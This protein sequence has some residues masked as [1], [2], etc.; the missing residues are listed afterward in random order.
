MYVLRDDQENI[1]VNTYSSIRKNH[2]RI[3]IQSHV[4]SGKTVVA[5]EITRRAV[6]KNN[7][8]LFLAPRRQL[9]YQTVETFLDFGIN[10]GMI[11]AGE[12]RSPSKLVQV[13][14]FDTITSRVGNGRMELPEASL[15]IVD[16]AHLCVSPARIA[17]LKNYNIVL[18]LTA[19]PALANGKGMGFFYEDIVESLTM[20]QMVDNGFLVPMRYFIGNAPDVSNV[21]LNADGD[22][23]EKELASVNDTPELIGDVFSN[24]K[25][26]AGDRCT[27]V[28]AVNRKHAVHLHNEWVSH[29]ITTEYIDGNTPPNERESIK[30]NVMSGITQVVINIGVMVAGVNWPRFDCVVIARQTRNISAW[31]QMI[32]RTSRLYP[33]KTE[34]L[35][36]YHG[37]NFEE[38]GRIDDPIEWSLD[39]ISTVKERKEKAQKAAKEPKEMEC[40][41]GAIFKARRICPACGNELLKK[42]EQIPFHS[43][44]LQEAIESK[45]EKYKPADKAQWYSEFL[46]Y[47]RRNSKPDSF[48][49]AMFQSKFK[50]WPYNKHSIH[51]SEPGL[52][53]INYIKSRNIAWSKGKGKAA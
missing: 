16:E 45:P 41:C 47:A 18:G 5:S 9:I 50:E 35:V 25:R 33:G 37:D 10:C 26:I 13:A 42:G 46:G 12:P 36:I 14:S 53:T 31:I 7:G 29:G 27:L 1:I 23:I 44:D 8:V 4:G 6:N 21:H 34:S 11:M 39:D 24:W 17:V 22:Y 43:C 2:K 51:P 15:V 19:T 49:L 30:N 48:A 52:D 3:I 38:L 40:Q 28:F 20:K 32:G